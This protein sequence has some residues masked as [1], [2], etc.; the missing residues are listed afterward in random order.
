MEQEIWRMFGV[1]GSAI[2]SIQQSISWGHVLISKEDNPNNITY[3]EDGE[4]A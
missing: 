3:N 4:A 1:T 2:Y